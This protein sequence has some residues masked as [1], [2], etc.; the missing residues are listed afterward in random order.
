[1]PV[2][3]QI[4]G[5]CETQLSITEPITP[6]PSLRS[7]L[8]QGQSSHHMDDKSNCIPWPANSW[9]LNTWLASTCTLKPNRPQYST[10]KLSAPRWSFTLQPIFGSSTSSSVFSF[11][12]CTD[13]DP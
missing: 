1:M 4:E 3:T 6:A 8:L 5:V 10:P 12:E 9:R 13:T 11:H 7:S 2:T